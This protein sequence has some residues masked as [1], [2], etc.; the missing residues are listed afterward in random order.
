MQINMARA[1][2]LVHP[3]AGIDNLEFEAQDYSVMKMQ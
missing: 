2:A 1:A 3:P